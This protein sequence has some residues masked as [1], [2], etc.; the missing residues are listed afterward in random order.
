MSKKV[1]KSKMELQTCHTCEHCVYIGEGEYICDQKDE[2]AVVLIDFSTPA[3][4][5]MICKGKGYKPQ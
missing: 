4:D 2:P 1:K 5:Y 3:E